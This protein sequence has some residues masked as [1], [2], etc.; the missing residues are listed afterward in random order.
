MLLV[1]SLYAIS[2][3]IVCHW[4]KHCMILAGASDEITIFVHHIIKN[5]AT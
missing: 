2:E 1:K 4:R 5:I 3:I